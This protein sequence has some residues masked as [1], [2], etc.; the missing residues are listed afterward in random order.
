MVLSLNLWHRGKFK[1]TFTSEPDDQ[2]VD[3]NWANWIGLMYG[4]QSKDLTSQAR[5]WYNNLYM[6]RG[7]ARYLLINIP[8]FLN[9]IPW[10]AFPL[11]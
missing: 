6:I 2:S 8:P 5:A 1:K 9:I 3:T 10:Q 7:S 4:S 11:P